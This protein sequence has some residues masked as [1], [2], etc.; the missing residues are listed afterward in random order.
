MPVLIVHEIGKEPT[1]ETLEGKVVTIGRSPDSDVLLLDP[2]VS[3]LHAMIRQSGYKE[4]LVK[5]AGKGN[6]VVVNGKEIK[7]PF[8]LREGAEIRIG[9]VL[10][11]FSSRRGRK[12]ERMGLPTTCA[13][14]ADKC[15]RDFS[16]LT[17]TTS[18]KRD[19][20]RFARPGT[21]FCSW[22]NVGILSMPAATMGGRLTYPP[23]PMTA[24]GRNRSNIA[25]DCEK[26]TPAL[27]SERDFLSTFPSGIPSTTIGR[28]GM[29]VSPAMRSSIEPLFPR[30]TSCKC[31]SRLFSSSAMATA[32][33]TCPP[34][35]PPASAILMAIRVTWLS[36]YVLPIA[37]LY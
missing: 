12:S 26:P 2:A 15:S 31:G 35:P 32:G 14:F 34:L 37:G 18:A 4:Y 27:R 28:N 11:I 9:P 16:K 21:Q 36:A 20:T 25:S 8:S 3:R 30:Y 24:C 22:I 10:L 23:V 6:I 19:P 7:D 5:P 13:T 1:L 33:K 29:P 17:T